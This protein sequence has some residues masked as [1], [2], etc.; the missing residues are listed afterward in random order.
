[1]ILGVEQKNRMLDTLRDM[2]LSLHSGNPGTSGA[3]EIAGGKYLRLQNVLGPAKGA[4]KTSAQE[5]AFMDLPECK[6][7]HVGFWTMEQGGSFLLGGELAHAVAVPPGA[8]LRFQPGTL[9][10]TQA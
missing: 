1:M 4:N 6:V 9:T 2:Y 5:I 10:I 7:T 3:H 8:T